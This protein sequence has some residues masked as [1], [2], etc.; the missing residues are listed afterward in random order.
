[1]DK[2]L[3]SIS[4]TLAGTAIDTFNG[5]ATF[6]F[7]S[8]IADRTIRLVYEELL[9]GIKYKLH[10]LNLARNITKVSII[11]YCKA[12]GMGSSE[13]VI[14]IERDPLFLAAVLQTH[15][16]LKKMIKETNFQRRLAAMN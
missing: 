4:D 9:L 5:R 1:M 7:F 14:T 11:A 16:A 8:G 6:I 13:Q 15:T 2:R 12:I 3:Q 10:D